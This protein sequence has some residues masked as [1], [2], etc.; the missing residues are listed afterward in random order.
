MKHAWIAAQDK[1]LNGQHSKDDSR[2]DAHNPC[3]RQILHLV[4]GEDTDDSCYEQMSYESSDKTVVKTEHKMSQRGKSV[5]LVR[6]YK[7]KNNIRTSFSSWRKN[8][9]K[10]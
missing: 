2:K 8:V 3:Q 7:G 4:T 1:R 10:A 9:A 6:Q 5:L